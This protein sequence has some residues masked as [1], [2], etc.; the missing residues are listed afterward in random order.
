M[1]FRPIIEPQRDVDALSLF[2][3][4]L[5]LQKL[6]VS[7]FHHQSQIQE[8]PFPFPLFD[9]YESYYMKRNLGLIMKE[10]IGSDSE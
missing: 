4:L 10:K 3:V 7:Q 1:T 2:N 6:K 5:P 8:K 9:N